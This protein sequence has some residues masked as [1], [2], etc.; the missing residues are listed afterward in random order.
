MN[1]VELF[2]VKS[3]ELV[4]EGTDL[5]SLIIN[6]IESAKL[7]LQDDDVLVVASK[8]VAIAE[9]R[10]INLKSVHYSKKASKLA[11]KARI[12][13]QFAQLILDEC[14]G[15]ILGV[16]PG[17]ITTIN[18]YGLLANAGADQSNAG[19]NKVILLPKNIKAS[20]KRI[21]EGLKKQLN[22]Y[23]GIIIADSRTMPLRLGTVGGA[24][25]TYGFEP[26][27]DE[28]GKIDLF[29]RPMHITVRALADQIATAAELLMGETNE[30]IPFVVTRGVSIKR[31]NEEEE[32]NINNLIKP[33]QCMF[34][35]PLLPRKVI[36]KLKKMRK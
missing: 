6:S 20:A 25:A 29:G 12:P 26:I 34:L 17:A 16:V 22:R 21:H 35:G 33:E 19:K 36:K 11:K 10:V 7:E 1:K 3:I 32:I 15:M 9:G 18:Q 28:R 8:I 23:V 30:Q 14:D 27:I 13:P 2:P 5:I 31:I 24:L 4:R